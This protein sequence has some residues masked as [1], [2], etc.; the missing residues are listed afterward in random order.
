MTCLQERGCTPDQCVSRLSTPQET[1]TCSGATSHP[2]A[3]LRPPLYSLSNVTDSS[4]GNQV[5]PFGAPVSFQ[6]F[7]ARLV[8][9]NVLSASVTGS[10]SA[11]WQDYPMTPGGQ[12][13]VLQGDPLLPPTGHPKRRQDETVSF[14][15]GSM[16]DVR[17]SSYVILV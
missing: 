12:E 10:A 5:F 15:T 4:Q 17:Y 7:H 1:A 16:L 11:Q 9:E 6:H 8:N 13:S 14:Q 2:T 3:T